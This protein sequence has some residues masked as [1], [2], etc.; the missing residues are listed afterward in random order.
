MASSRFN[1]LAD[2]C[3]AHL[4]SSLQVHRTYSKIYILIKFKT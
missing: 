4:I 1:L 3:W 2:K